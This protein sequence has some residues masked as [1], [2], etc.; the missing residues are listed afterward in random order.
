M[1]GKALFQVNRISCWASLDLRFA[2][3]FLESPFNTFFHKEVVS[4]NSVLKKQH[5]IRILSSFNAYSCVTGSLLMKFIHAA[6]LHKSIKKN[7]TE[8]NLHVKIQVRYSICYQ[9]FCFLSLFFVTEECMR[10]VEF[11]TAS[12]KVII[13]RDINL[14]YTNTSNSWWPTNM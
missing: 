12:N 4:A 8:A 3:E 6:V 7:T 10:M 5:P 2:T 11:S 1:S 9:L 14:N 13:I